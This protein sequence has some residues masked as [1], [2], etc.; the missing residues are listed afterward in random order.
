MCVRFVSAS[1]GWWSVLTIGK[2]GSSAGQLEYYE[3][4]VAAGVEDY[5]AGRGEVPGVWLGAGVEGL[6]VAVGSRVEREGF[7][8]LMRGCHPVDGSLLRSMGRSSTVAA[9]D[10]T[11]SAPKSVSVLFAVA[12]GEV[13]PALV[14]AHERAVAAAVVFL[15]REACRTRRGHGGADRVPGEGFVAAA[16]RH[17]LSRAGDPQLH[18]HV[19]VGN[20]TRADGR[21]T[22]LDAHALYEYKSSAGAVYRAVLRAEIRERLPWVSW[23]RTA[24]GLF[25]IDGVPQGCCGISRSGERRS[26]STPASSPGPA[27]PGGCR[28]SGCRGSRSPPVKPRATLALMGRSGGR[29]RAPG[30]P[31]T[32]SV[33]GST[34]RSKLDHRRLQRGRRL[35]RRWRGCPVRTG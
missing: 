21:Y 6:G 20:L 32:G 23:T 13:L 15:E 4:Q 14:E 26:S 24:R 18:T 34:R 28:G 31:S 9:L 3:R 12:G 35:R 1:A 19:V 8:A 16:Y 30:P 29:T 5:Y 2:L 33:R 7:M 27:P 25:E 11:F 22:A 10:L 17:R